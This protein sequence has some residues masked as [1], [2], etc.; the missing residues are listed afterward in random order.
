MIRKKGRREERKNRQ[1]GKEG[2]MEEGGEEGKRRGW[3]IRQVQ[4]KIERG[5]VSLRLFCS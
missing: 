1:E 3:L 4:E 5:A 2:G